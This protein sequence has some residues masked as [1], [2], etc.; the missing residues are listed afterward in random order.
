MRAYG[1]R[2]WLASVLVILGGTNGTAFAQEGPVAQAPSVAADYQVG[3]GDVLQVFVWRN[4]ELSVTLPVRPDGR[5][6]TP[7]VEDMPAAGKTTAQLAR[8]IEG[9]LAQYVRTPQ[10]NVI[11]T[12]PRS[13]MSE[14]KVL[15]QVRN[16]Q[17]VPYRDG[18]TV[19]DVVLTVG[20]LSEFASGNRA[21]IVR[22]ENGK[23]QEIRVRLKDLV[24][25]G[26]MRWN[27]E[28]RPGDV[29]IVPE[30]LF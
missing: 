20:G 6:T 5:I 17:A 3:A 13:V 15:G 23:S 16:P 8:D 26:N 14:V 24:D 2:V 9:V 25:G 19:L 21:K 22:S 29:L 12:T 27:L 11:V 1:F 4:P 18:L 28:L 30:S 10:V 7:L